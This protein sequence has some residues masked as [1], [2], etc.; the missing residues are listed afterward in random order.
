MTAQR[1]P[2]SAPNPLVRLRDCGQAVWL[3]FLARPFL[4]EGGLKRLVEQDR[5]LAAI[6]FGFGGH[7]EGKEPSD[8]EP[9]A[10]QHA[11]E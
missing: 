4:L 5:M 10:N 6:R 3:D 2:K 1:Q 9:K 7:I 11:A 8:P